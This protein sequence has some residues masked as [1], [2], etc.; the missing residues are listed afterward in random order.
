MIPLT[1][2]I[3]TYNERENIERTIAALSWAESILLIDSGSSDGTTELARSGHADVRVVERQ[4]DSFANQCNFGLSQI[5]TEWVL[6]LDADYIVTPELRAEIAALDPAADVAAYSIRFRYCIFGRPLRS[7]VYP[8]RT[9]LY[10]RR[11]ARYRDEGHGHRVV[12]DGNVRALSTKIEHD[13]R[14]G[15]SHWLGSQD[16]Y[17]RIEARYLLSQP[18]AELSRQDRLRRRIFFSP[19][20]MFLYLLFARG[21]IFDGWPGWFYICQRTIAELLLSM[22][23]LTEREKLTN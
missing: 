15:L 18:L 2:L 16:T 13:D 20:V 17:A 22:R 23:L 19:A 1:V 12:I 21:L 5:T 9:V 8:A 6:S 10:R 7:T 11:V 4:F 3:L 14:K